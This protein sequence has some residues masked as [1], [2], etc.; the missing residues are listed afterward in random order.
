MSVHPAHFP[1]FH[2]KDSDF[3][4]QKFGDNRQDSLC[5]YGIYNL[6][7]KEWALTTSAQ[8]VNAEQVLYLRH[9]DTKISPVDDQNAS[10]SSSP[11]KRLRSVSINSDTSTPDKRSRH[12]QHEPVSIS[13]DEDTSGATS[14]YALYLSSQ[15]RLLTLI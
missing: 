11:L 7:T 15:R 4:Q 10:A 9:E 1:F 12:Q 2:P 13:D 5:C 8:R 14:G 6:K 3:L